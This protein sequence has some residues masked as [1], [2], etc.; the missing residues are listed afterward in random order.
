MLL[1]HFTSRYHLQQILESEKLK[2]TESNVSPL[3]P[4]A[5][6]P[7]VWLTNEERWKKQ[8]WHVGAAV[9]KLEFKFTVLIPRGDIKRWYDFAAEHNVP[10]HWMLALEENG[11]DG[12]RWFVLERPIP[13]SEW[14]SI[15]HVPTGRRL[16]HPGA[17][18]RQGKVEI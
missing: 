1:F 15:V 14:V 11:G 16:W 13:S 2:T 8:G 10:S 7:V 17:E 6:P 9:N 18:D 3:K 12:S 4:N 5:G